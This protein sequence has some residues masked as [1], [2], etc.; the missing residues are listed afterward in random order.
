MSARFEW[1]P[2]TEQK[3]LE[4]LALDDQGFIDFIEK[5]AALIGAREYDEDVLTNALAYPWE[6]PAESYLLSG[7]DATLLTSL[8]PEQR[9][10]LAD[11]RSIEG[12]ETPTRFP[13]LSFGSNAAPGRLATKLEELPAGHRDVAVISGELHDFDVGVSAHA[14]VYGA[15]PATIFVSPGT[16]ARAAVL[17]V[18]LE[19]LTALAW[20]EMSY[21]LGRLDDI[22]FAPDFDAPPIDSVLLFASRLGAHSVDGEVVAMEAVEARNRTAPPVSQQLLLDGLAREMLGPEASA[23]DVVKLLFEDFAVGSRRVRETMRASAVPFES[24][25]W[26]RFGD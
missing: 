1:P 18:T 4:R 3:L 20:T 15:F 17:W 26:T 23:R 11:G 2:L 22:E 21:F 14:A 13:L 19:Q 9:E 7:E 8:S 24:D 12:S 25:R 6:R 10:S 5:I 16:A